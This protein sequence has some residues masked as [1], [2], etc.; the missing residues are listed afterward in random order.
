MQQKCIL[1]RT[2]K[3]ADSVTPQCFSP[4]QQAYCE[5]KLNQWRSVAR[6]SR[7]YRPGTQTLEA[8]L[9]QS[10]V[11]SNEQSYH[12]NDNKVPG[13]QFTNNI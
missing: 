9:L 8:A 4:K 5:N 10:L 1:K 3:S 7:F 2:V 13:A 12:T 6:T 11:K